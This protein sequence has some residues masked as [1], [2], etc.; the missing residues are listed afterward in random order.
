MQWWK[1]AI[2]Y[3][4]YPR[5]FLD[6]N[7]DG[8]GDIPGIIRRLDYLRELGVGAIWLCPVYRSPNA[9]NG[10]DVSDY[11][12]VNPEYGTMADMDRLIREAARRGIRVIMDLV[13]NHTSTEHP[14]FQKSRDRR[15]PYTDY[16]YWSRGDGDGGAPN[17]W[18]GFFGADCW[19]F[20]P[21]RCEYYLHLFD[22]SQADLN[23]H[24][25]AVLDEIK[26]IMRFWLNKGVAGFRL[27]VANVI[28]KESLESSKKQ[29]ILTGMEHYLSN[30]GCHKILRQLRKVLDEYD[31]F[32]IG[33]AVFVTPTMARDLCGWDRKE[34]DMVFS[35]EHMECDQRFVKWLKKKCKPK[36]FFDCLIR[37]QR[38]LEWNAIYLE[39]HDQ[40]RSIP[41]FGSRKYWKKSGKL[42]AALLLTMRGTPFIYQGQEIGMTGFDFDSM[43][44]INDI[45][46]RHIDRIL[47]RLH[48]PSKIRWKIISRASRD[49]ARTP[50]QWTGGPGAGFT[51]GRPWLGIN[52][53]YG[54]VNL[55]AQI[56][57]PD[58][59]WNWYR[60]LCALRKESEVL[61]RGEFVLLEASETVF[62]YSRELRGKTLTIALNF[63]DKPA[64]VSHQGG[65]VRSNYPRRRFDG[66]LQPWEA[67]ILDPAQG[68]EPL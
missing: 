60:D 21:E 1:D 65:L 56:Q 36:D 40:P 2:I 64:R 55:E 38:G 3:Q 5:S 18:T 34:L 22:R 30:D 63:S 7:G 31:A 23:Y 48:V 51:K 10:Y 47:T 37:W 53:N 8:V 9:D 15:G 6:S 49:N 26:D 66:V 16:Y 45:E 14:W 57:D 61:R 11:R 33:E 25:P 12:S 67:V 29:P 52:R 42:L 35:F 4:I 44:Q 54:K 68:G 28:W 50:F 24:N 19:D 17:N 32:A 39:N 59:I 43:R 62:A 20:D 41:R 27:D 46:S 58:S 13:L